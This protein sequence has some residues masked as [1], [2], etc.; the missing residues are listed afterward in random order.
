MTSNEMVWV[1]FVVCRSKQHWSHTKRRLRP[2]AKVVQDGNDEGCL[3]LDRLPITGEAAIIRE[4][5]GIRKRRPAETADHLISHR[6]IS[7]KPTEG[8]CSDKNRV[9]ASGQ[10]IG[11]EPVPVVLDAERAGCRE[12]AKN[13]APEM[14]PAE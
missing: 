3:K 13:P 2:F 7:E 14:E 12:V 9:S 10:A 8:I 11:P 1:M 5:L 4:V 6:L